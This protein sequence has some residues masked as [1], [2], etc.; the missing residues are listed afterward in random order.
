MILKHA[1]I[2]KATLL[3]TL[4]LAEQKPTVAIIDFDS[5]GIGKNQVNMLVERLRTEIG[6]TKL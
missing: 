4:I 1:Y 3:I 6:N 2:L 5:Y